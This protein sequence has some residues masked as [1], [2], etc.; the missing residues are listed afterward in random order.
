MLD[1]FLRPRDTARVFDVVKCTMGRMPDK[2]QVMIVVLMVG[3]WW[4]MRALVRTQGA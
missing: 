1:A 4:M 3:G 2:K